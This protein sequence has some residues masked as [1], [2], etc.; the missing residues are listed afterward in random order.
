MAEIGKSWVLAGPRLWIA[1]A[2]VLAACSANPQPEVSERSSTSLQAVPPTLAGSSAGSGDTRPADLDATFD[3]RVRELVEDYTFPEPPPPAGG[4]EFFEW[5]K[6]CMGQLGFAVEVLNEPGQDPT[7]FA[8]N[9]TQPRQHD[10]AQRACLHIVVDRGLFVPLPST[11]D[12]IRR[13]YRAYLIVQEC[14]RDHGYPTVD[15]PSEDVF[16]DTW[17]NGDPRDRWHPYAATPFGG[18]LSV[19]PGA[20]GNAPPEVSAQ[21]RMQTACPADLGTI[22]R[23]GYGTP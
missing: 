10:G 11:E 14:L 5:G 15:P 1:V 12:E 21:L 7:L 23:D 19:V 22:L 9:I 20:E 17:F 4:L 3:A 6:W 18:S 2:V 13:L 16:V 8:A